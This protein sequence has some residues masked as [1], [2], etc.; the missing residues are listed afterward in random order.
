MKKITLFSLLVFFLFVKPAAASFFTASLNLEQLIEFASDI[1]TG[2]VIQV[3][4]GWDSKKRPVVTVALAVEE[5]YK[6]E[7]GARYTF[8]QL[9]NMTEE[10]LKGR[11]TLIDGMPVYTKGEHLFLF[12]S[13]P[14]PKSGLTAP[15][16]ILQGD[17]KIASS[18]DGQKTVMNPVG[19]ENLFGTLRSSRSPALKTFSTSERKLIRQSSPGPVEYNSFRSLVQ[20]L[21]AQ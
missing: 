8:T 6:G 19:N 5:V 7:V 10:E 1:F 2:E 9:R 13:A 11:I 21:T 14:H 3:E 17:F 4:N 12:M 16:G 18:A 15:I 20:K